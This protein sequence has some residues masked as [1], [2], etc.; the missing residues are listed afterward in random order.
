MENE[1]FCFS[2]RPKADATTAIG[3][4][5]KDNIKH[6]MMK[7][8]LLMAAIA[9]TAIGMHAQNTRYVITGVAPEGAKKVYM[10]DVADYRQVDSVEVANGKFQLHGQKPKDAFL[11]VYAGDA[12][13]A[14]IND[15]T[16]I[17]INLKNGT[18]TGSADNVQFTDFQKS[19]QKLI[20]KITSVYE[21][22]EKT[23]NDQTIEG[24]T[25]TKSLE[26]QFDQLAQ[27]RVDAI[28]KFTRMHKNSATPAYFLG[29]SYSAFSYDELTEVLDQN[30]KY[31]NH[32]MMKVVRRQ[33][34]GLAK[35]RNGL[36]YHEL[37]MKNMDLKTVRLSQ[38]AGKGKY[39]LVDFWASWCGP[40][41]Q[42]MPNVVDAY[43]RYHAAKG[44]EVIGVS[45]DTKQDQWMK[46]VKDLGMA[47]PQMSDLKGWKSYAA[48]A[49]G[50]NSIPSNVL[51]DP[52]GNI[53]ASDL[54]GSELTA[55]L[56]EIYGY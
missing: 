6:R 26:K 40:C 48:E 19:Q 21:D 15:N 46:G 47:W 31:Y 23:K 42:E 35:R 53:I 32:P 39:V 55:K 54:R 45:F 11:Y 38:W 14:V 12:K 27:N 24:L 7:Q 18:V 8:F 50:I 17:S 37:T 33:H 28:L 29:Q 36:R 9:I 30:A 2:Y 16:P 51:L 25:K 1:Y 41:R 20:E 43:K 22:L 13:V 5:S 56:K 3:N 44:F 52:E 34:E 10:F 49:Y 4:N